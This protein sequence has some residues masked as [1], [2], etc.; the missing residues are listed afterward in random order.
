MN[1]ITLNGISSLLVKGLLIQE[2]PP[3]VKPKIRTVVEEVDGR[4]GDI[5]T[6]LGYS[7]YDK[8]AIIGLHGDYD[9]DQVIYFFNSEGEVIFSNEPDKYYKYEILDEIEFERLLRFKK[10]K[11]KFHVQPFKY[12][13]VDNYLD[14]NTTNLNQISIMNDGNTISKPVF[15]IHGSGT[16]NLSINGAEIFVINLGNEEY[17]AIDSAQMNAY[18]DG[19]LKNR[20]VSGDYENL[21]LSIGNNVISWVGN[22]TRIEITDYS[23]WI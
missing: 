19:V 10:A 6:K 16:I 11:V 23:R 9:V 5:V 20:L 14:L 2:L 13:A 7:A 3:I 4:D 15:T 21:N 8:E 18:K 22:V 12:S 1:T 17:I